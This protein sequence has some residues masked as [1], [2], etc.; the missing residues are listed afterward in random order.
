M[1]KMGQYVMELQEGEP[2]PHTPDPDYEAD[3]RE[4]EAILHGKVKKVLEDKHLEAAK[5][6]HK[7]LLEGKR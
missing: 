1:S 2:E 7:Q 5:V 3:Y 6:I 4:M